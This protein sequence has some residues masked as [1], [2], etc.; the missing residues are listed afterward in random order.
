MPQVTHAALQALSGLSRLRQ[1][2]WHVGDVTDMLPDVSCFKGL[3]SLV[4]FHLPS[5]L[6]GQFARWNGYSALPP[7]CDAH[8]EMPLP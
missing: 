3:A 2:R 4:A 1:L 7:L 5:Y 6:H 8:V